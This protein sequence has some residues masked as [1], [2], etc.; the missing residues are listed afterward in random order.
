MKKYKPESM[1]TEQEKE[2]AR[3]KE[4]AELYVNTGTKGMKKIEIVGVE[5]SYQWRADVTQARDITL[6]YQ[7]IGSCGETEMKELI[8]G[9]MNLYL[10]KNLLYNWDQ[11]F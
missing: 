2:D 9:T 8:P 5:Q 1:M 10:D 3:A 11:I 6:E 7:K 4:E